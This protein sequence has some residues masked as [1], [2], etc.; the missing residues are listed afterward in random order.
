MDETIRIDR[1]L[2]G[3]MSPQERQGFEEELAGNAD[4]REQLQLQR[5]M[6]QFLQHQEERAELQQKLTHTGAEFFPE[7]P[8][9][10]RLWVR[11]IAGSAAAAAVL[12]LIVWQVFMQPSLYDSYAEFPPLALTEKSTTAPVDWSRTEAAFNTGEYA[13]AAEQLEQYL[14]SFPDDQQ[15]RLYLGM[16]R[17]ELGQA[18]EANAIFRQ[19][20]DAS[21]DIRAYANWYRALN[22]LKA[23]E[24]DNCRAVLEGIPPTSPFYEE[25]QELLGKL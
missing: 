1:Y 21:P 22:Y 5:S 8:A 2:S 14:E 4:L 19:L 24:E 23:G 7:K 9:R 18:E 13:T 3:E 17:M 15:A 20:A 6:Q 10:S 25:A 11:W 16:A 12:L